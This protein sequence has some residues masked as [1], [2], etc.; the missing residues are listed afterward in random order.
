MSEFILTTFVVMGGALAL[1][2]LHSSWLLTRK[3]RHYATWVYPVVVVVTVIFASSGVRDIQGYPL[4]EK[5]VGDW[6]YLTH[7]MEGAA[8]VV[9]LKQKEVRVH[10]FVP[11]EKEKSAMA[12]AKEAKD[13]GQ[14]TRLNTDQPLPEM[15]LI[16]ID[17]ESPKNDT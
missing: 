3:I 2:A 14:R 6:E 8:A 10:R 7:H 5:P 15:E 4:N 11:T 17:Q 12:A 13:R 1:V 9:T 16:R